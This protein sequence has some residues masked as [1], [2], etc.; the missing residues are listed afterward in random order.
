MKQVNDEHDNFKEGS[1]HFN[2]PNSEPLSS[3]GDDVTDP[4]KGAQ[5]F[6]KI[7]TDETGQE[8]KHLRRPAPKKPIDQ[9]IK[10]V[11]NREGVRVGG[12]HST[13]PSLLGKKK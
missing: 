7:A 11:L 4:V 13:A 5:I 10:E 12:I 8:R 3:V 2:L 1:A 9:R 6:Q